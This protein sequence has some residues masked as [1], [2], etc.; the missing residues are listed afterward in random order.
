M[1][2]LRVERHVK[3][4]TPGSSQ[5][6]VGHVVTITAIADRFLYHMMRMI[7]GTLVIIRYRGLKIHTTTNL[8]HL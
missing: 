6:G 1:H 4:A 3:P 2:S 7:S 8:A 5:G